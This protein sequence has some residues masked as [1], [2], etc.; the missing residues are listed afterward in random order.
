MGELLISPYRC[1]VTGNPVGTDTIRIGFVCGCQGCRA[2]AEITRLRAEVERLQQRCA[3][4]AASYGE[5]CSDLE[6]LK[7]QNAELADARIADGFARYDAVEA[8]R[9][10]AFE[11]AAQI[12]K[13]RAKSNERLAMS[14]PEGSDGRRS[15]VE[16]CKEDD[17][18]AF[19]IEAAAIRQAAS[20]E[21]GT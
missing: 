5:K 20:G 16:R 17:Q 14:Y 19:A 3:E 1:D 12:A 10:E 9:A 6:D 11:R 2:A 21:S 15:A 18:V 8:A 13:D 7:R 4:W